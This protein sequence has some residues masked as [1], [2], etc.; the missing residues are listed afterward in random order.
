MLPGKLTGA[1]APR[2]TVGRLP[3]WWRRPGIGLPNPTSTSISWQTPVIGRPWISRTKL[4]AQL[5]RSTAASDP[6]IRFAWLKRR[7]NSIRERCPL[8]SGHRICS[9]DAAARAHLDLA[10]CARAYALEI[11]PCGGA[12]AG[13]SRRWRPALA[14]GRPGAGAARGSSPSA[15][16]FSDPRTPRR[17]SPAAWPVRP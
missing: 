4:H 2:S 12:S 1:S 11:T 15:R 16:S 13:R 3:T 6:S 5:H 9:V 8:W 17:S 14:G 10:A 7:S